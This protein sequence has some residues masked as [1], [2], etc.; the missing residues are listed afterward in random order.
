MGLL[1]GSQLPRLKS[2]KPEVLQIDTF[3]G[4]A[5]VQFSETRLKKNEAR[6]SLNLMLIEDGIWDKRW[7]TET[8]ITMDEDIDGFTEYIKSDGTRELIIV[9][10]STVYKSTDLVSTSAIS[11]TVTLTAG[12][13]CYFR[14]IGAYLY[15]GN[16]VD[17]YV[18][19]NGTAVSQASEINT[20]GTV[21]PSRGAGLSSGSFNYYY[22]VTASNDIGE[23]DPSAE[24]TIGVNADRD[25]WVPGDNDYI[26]LDWADVSGATKYSVYFSDTSGFEVKLAETTISSYRDDGTAV[27]N[28]FI[29]PPE[30]NTTGGPRLGQMWI[31]NNRLW[32]TEPENPYIV[33]F[34]GAGAFK[35]NFSS[36]FGGGYIELEKG[37]RATVVGGT[38][39]QGESHVICET[40]EGR[41]NVWKVTLQ[42]EEIDNVSFIVPIPTKI[43]GQVGSN[44]PGS[45]VLV[46]ND[47]MFSNKNGV[48]VLGNEPGILNQLRTAEL[49]VKLRPYFRSL[50]ADSVNRIA[51]YYHDAKVFISVATVS[52][53][54]NRVVVFDRE[55]TAWYKDWSIGFSQFGEFTDSGGQTYFL[56]SDGDKIKHISEAYEG[57]DGVAFTCKYVSPRI[58][59]TEDWTKFAKIKKAYLR[60]R[61]TVGSI[62]FSFTG[63]TKK[64]QTNVLAT[65]TIVPGSSD[66]GMGW[67]PMGSVQLGTTE[68]V[69]TTF[70]QESLIKYLRINKLI[71]DMQWTVQWSSL[72]SR[73]AITGLMAKGFI[74]GTGE[75]SDWKL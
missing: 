29:E 45:I 43:I 12:E 31:S 71:R 51:A 35:G 34:S 65:G 27:P 6:E 55:R 53:Q 21:T 36:A 8:K 10:D 38:D 23:T 61:N 57:D 72:T 24:A 52:G 30:E 58:P 11:G 60:L 64:E 49:S 32:G 25:T 16:G 5:N 47:A 9:S 1:S 14:Q 22:R 56:G 15:I 13:K 41:G 2:R 17:P 33:W 26:D 68:G 48:Q 67:D 20:P 69:P 7:G 44:A 28:T 70:A 63:T 4:G 42:S 46:E 40:P 62:Q 73:T 66:T 74:I 75:P 50:A 37:G 18:R 3:D 59:I 39:F 54:N 19:Y